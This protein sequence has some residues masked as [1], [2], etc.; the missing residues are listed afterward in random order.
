MPTFTIVVDD[1]AFRGEGLTRLE[2]FTKGDREVELGWGA[3]A[4][5]PPLGTAWRPPAPTAPAAR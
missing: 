1:E 3:A 4:A 5:E 2:A